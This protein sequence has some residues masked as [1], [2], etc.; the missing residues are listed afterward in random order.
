MIPKAV[1]KTIE[2]SS[3]VKIEAYLIPPREFRVGIA[4]ASVSLGYSKEWLGRVASRDGKALKRL[5]ELG[6]VGLLV[7]VEVDNNY[8]GRTKAQTISLDDYNVLIDYAVL[9]GK[10]EALALSRALRDTSLDTR[11]CR[12]YGI[13]PMPGWL[14]EL[15]MR[16]I[17]DAVLGNEEI[18][19]QF[20]PGDKDCY[21]NELIASH[22]EQE[23]E[24]N[25]IYVV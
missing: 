5:R 17:I 16:E 21:S 13:E 8:Q 1:R 19:A 6:F 4:S 10:L 15:K 14:Q 3:T 25:E 23:L 2:F 22:F 24:E 20:L 7:E 9:D 11:F 12:T 18:R